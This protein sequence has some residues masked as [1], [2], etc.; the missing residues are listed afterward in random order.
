MINVKRDY[1]SVY[2]MWTLLY[3]NTSTLTTTPG[4][5]NNGHIGLV[6]QDTFYMTISPTPYNAPVE[7]GGTSSVPQEE[8]TA[9]LSQL[10]DEHAEARRIHEN[11]HNMNAEL[12]T[13][14]LEE[15]N[16]TYVFAL[17]NILAG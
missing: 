6:I 9:Q 3:V 7:P 14:V 4:G 16:N 10:R 1:Q 8:T 12:K 2:G 11:H 17:R 15:A 5:G 13:M